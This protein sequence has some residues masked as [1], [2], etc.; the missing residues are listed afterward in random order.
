MPKP[1][2]LTHYS[3]PGEPRRFS[4][5]RGGEGMAVLAGGAG[6]E[7]RWGILAPWQGHGGKRPDPF[8]VFA[9]DDVARIP[10]LR[11]AKRCLVVADGFYAWR[12]IKAKLEPFYLSVAGEAYF[13]GLTAKHADDG[14][15]S[16]AIA[17][18][19]STVYASPIP[20]AGNQEWLAGGTPTAIEWR[21]RAVS[22]HFLDADDA[23]CIAPLSGNPNQ[24][25]LF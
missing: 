24:G 22:R 6:F 3:Q 23:D 9:L 21:E 4:V 7:M 19:A 11:R 5:P 14:V 2:S 13:C 16:F 12:Y 25:E 8:Y 20:L 17:M 18:T 1:P 10:T 15:A